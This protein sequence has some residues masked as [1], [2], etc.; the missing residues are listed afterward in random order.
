VVEV[1]VVCRCRRPSGPFR[2]CGGCRG[3]GSGCRPSG[4][5]LSCR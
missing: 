5:L 1:A 3:H 4:P 2:G